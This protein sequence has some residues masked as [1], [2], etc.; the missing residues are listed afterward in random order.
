MMSLAKRIILF[1]TLILFLTPICLAQKKGAVKAAVAGVKSEQLTRQV[2]Q[3][4]LPAVPQA[5]NVQLVQI[6]NYAEKPFLRIQPTKKM[7]S[8][9]KILPAQVVNGELFR[10]EVFPAPGL[11]KLPNALNDSSP[12]LYRGMNL[13]IKHIKNLLTNGLELEKSSFPQLYFSA[14]IDIALA[15]ANEENFLLPVLVKVNVTPDL[16][17]RYPPNL[18]EDDNYVFNQTIPAKYISD[19]MVFL[20]VD[21]DREW[22]KV[23][24]EDDELLFNPASTQLFPKRELVKHRFTPALGP[25]DVSLHSLWRDLANGREW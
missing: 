25:S 15:S 9:G 20:E 16:Q 1:A 8:S 7:N 17:V 18:Y 21:G 12:A 10:Q 2:A 3:K 5:T 13:Q 14:D 24:L 11:R 4:L 6:I 22:Y 23:T 19:V